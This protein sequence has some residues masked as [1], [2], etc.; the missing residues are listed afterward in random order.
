MLT[1]V[2]GV[3]TGWD[4]LLTYSEI[5]YLRRWEELFWYGGGMSLTGPGIGWGPRIRMCPKTWHPRSCLLHLT[6]W[7]I[8]SRKSHP[9]IY[10]HTTICASSLRSPPESD[11]I[12]S[13]YLITLNWIVIKVTNLVPPMELC[14][15]QL[16]L[17]LAT[18][19]K[20]QTFNWQWSITTNIAVQNSSKKKE[21][22]KKLLECHVLCPYCNT[23]INWSS[24]LD[25]PVGNCAMIVLEYEDIYD[26]GIMGPV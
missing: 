2:L 1:T 15:L 24:Q 18:H 26:E 7:P 17:Q 3:G 25:E 14:H 20:Q 12:Q 19:W 16:L 6:G 11:M 21:M 10:V 13:P 23:C 8:V 22:K 4:A 9:T 5:F